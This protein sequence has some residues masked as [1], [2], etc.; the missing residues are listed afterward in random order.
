MVL[1]RKG[2]KSVADDCSSSH[3][4]PDAHTTQVPNFAYSIALSKDLE[5]LMMLLMIC[6]PLLTE[7]S[8]KNHS[9]Q[10]R[11]SRLTALTT[12]N[13]EMDRTGHDGKQFRQAT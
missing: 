7:V 5:Q 3:D 12:K 6:A 11:H 2:S 10:C 9:V 1:T 8:G 13:T 4:K